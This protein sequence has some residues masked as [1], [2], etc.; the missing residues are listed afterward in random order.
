M[1]YMVNQSIDRL[2]HAGIRITPQRQAVL[3]YLIKT[4]THPTADEI[5]QSLE[6]QFP[7]IS[8]ATV[9]N[10]LKVFIEH[11]LVQELN[12]ADVS[13]RFEFNHA[14]HYHAV[15]TKCGKFEDIFYPGLEKVERATEEL[16]DFKIYGH[17]LELYGLC[18]AC[19]PD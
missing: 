9:Y 4:D 16:T 10:N 2:K 6:K 11:N 1:N 14:D 7:N 13:S 8:V 15:C 17:R 5:Y 18:K 19:Q 12:Y 3:E